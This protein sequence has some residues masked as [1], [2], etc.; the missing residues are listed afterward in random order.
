MITDHDYRLF[1]EQ[2]QEEENEYQNDLENDRQE[3][4]NE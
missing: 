4:E 2:D 3:V 1:T